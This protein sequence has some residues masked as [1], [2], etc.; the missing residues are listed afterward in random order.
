MM[1]LTV[2]GEREGRGHTAQESGGEKTWRGGGCW[3]S[4]AA[5]LVRV[6]ARVPRR[7][8]RWC[9][10]LWT[11]VEGTLGR[12]AGLAHLSVTK[13]LAFSKCID[14]FF[15]RRIRTRALC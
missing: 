3:V 9:G 15:E 11:A 14:S 6:L 1:N 10:G 13:Q 8:S 4:R 5:A 7:V 12:D 2:G